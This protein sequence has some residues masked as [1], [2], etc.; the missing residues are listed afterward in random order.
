MK[1]SSKRGCKESMNPF[2]SL[3]D[4]DTELPD[5]LGGNDTDSEYSEEDDDLFV[6]VSW[7]PTRTQVN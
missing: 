3:E 7:E 4:D 6:S 2:N 5:I 1:T